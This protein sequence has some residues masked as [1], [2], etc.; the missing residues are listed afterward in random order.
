MTVKRE[1]MSVA[2]MT[3]RVVAFPLSNR[4]STIRRCARELENIHGAAATR[5]WRTEC[6][7][8][9]DGLKAIGL[10]EDEIRQQVMA[11]QTEVQ[12]ELMHRYSQRLEEQRAEA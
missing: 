6:T 9:A 7:A 10:P 4:T 5:Y 1:R 8:L 12:I 2:N 11:F 3:D